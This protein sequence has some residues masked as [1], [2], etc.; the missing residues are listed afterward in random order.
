MKLS[1]SVIA[2]RYAE[3][4]GRIIEFLNNIFEDVHKQNAEITNYFLVTFDLLANQLKLYF[5]ALDSIDA[6][7]KV[8]SEDNYRRM[9]KNP[10]IAV[11]NH[12]HQEI[13]KI[14]S[15]YSLSPTNQAKLKRIQN[16]DDSEDAET[17][18]K[19]LVE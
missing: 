6:E 19:S 4:D 17:L 7:K 18:L 14:L 1:K 3:Y 9:A 8:S 10:A 11:M 15:E 5:L 13:L 16:G 12:A 2:S